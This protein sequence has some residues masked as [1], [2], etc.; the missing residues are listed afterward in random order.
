MNPP[1]Q[2]EQLLYESPQV[3]VYAAYAHSGEPVICLRLQEARASPAVNP[4]LQPRRLYAQL[5]SELLLPVLEM[6]SADSPSFALLKQDGGFSVRQFI[7]QRPPLEACFDFAEALIRALAAM[8]QAKIVLT[9]LTPALLWYHPDTATLRFLHLAYATRT[10]FSRAGVGFHEGSLPYIAPEQTGRIPVRPDYRSNYYSVGLILYELFTGAHPLSGSDTLEW[11]HQHLARQP[12]PAVRR[13]PEIGQ[14]LSDWLGKLLAKNPDD[15]YQSTQAMQEDLIAAR[16]LW[17]GGRLEESI[18]LGNRDF[19]EIFVLPE[20]IVGRDKDLAALQDAIADK[21][22][23]KVLLYLHGEEGIGKTAL[24]QEWAYRSQD[25]LRWVFGAHRAGSA[26]PFEALRQIVSGLRNECL[27]LPP[28]DRAYLQQQLAERTRNLSGVLIRFAPELAAILPSGNGMVS[29]DGT[30][31]FS[32]FAYA[33]SQFLGAFA[34]RRR[35][36]VL[37]LENLDL[38]EPSTFRL[39]DGLITDPELQHLVLIGTVRQR[40]LT[41]ETFQDFTERMRSFT[42]DRPRVRFREIELG[43]LNARHIAGLLETVVPEEQTAAAELIYHKT[44]G[45]PL[46]VRQLLHDMVDEGLFLRQE[47]ARAWRV[48]LDGLSQ[49][50]ATRNMLGLVAN[51][52]ESLPPQEQALLRLAA[53][54]GETFDPDLLARLSPE[55][56]RATFQRLSELETTSLVFRLPHPTRFGA[57][58]FSNER[59]VR[60]LR[61]GLPIEQRQ[62]LMA[63]ILRYYLG[64]LSEQD[65]EE[66]LFRL[67]SFVMQMP[68][69]ERRRW[70][71][72]LDRAGEKA[73]QQ[74][75]FDNAMAYYQSILDALPG[76]SWTEQRALSLDYFFKAIQ[77]A[78]FAQDYRLAGTWLDRLEPRVKGQDERADWFYLRCLSLVNQGRMRETVETAL[79]GLRELG[80]K[81]PFEPP[82]WRIIWGMIHMD[83]MYKGTTRE[84]IERLPDSRIPRR[85][86]YNRL[87]IVASPAIYFAA[88]KLLGLICEFRMKDMYRQGKTPY[89]PSIL[90]NYGFLTASFTAKVALGYD[91][92]RIGMDLN[93]VYGMPELEPSNRFLFSTF[94]EHARVNLRDVGQHLVENYRA[95]RELGNNNIGFYSLGVGIHYLWYSGESFDRLDQLCARYLPICQDA[96]QPM[97]E[98]YLLQVQQSLSELQRERFSD[99]LFMGP[100]LEVDPADMTRAIDTSKN[101]DTT[102]RG[103]YIALSYLK[104]DY[105]AIHPVGELILQYNA[106]RGHNSVHANFNVFF[107]LSAL[108]KDERHTAQRTRRFYRKH[109]YKLKHWGQSAP[110]HYGVLFRILQ[111]L[112]Y[113]RRGKKEA[114]ATLAEAYAVALEGDNP[115][116]KGLAAEEWGVLLY[117]RETTRRLGQKVMGEAWQHY[118]TWG[119]R[120]KQNQ[121]LEQW[122]DLV[123]TSGRPTDLM[124]SIDLDSV[125][126][127][128]QTISSEIRQQ[129]LLDRLLGVVMENAGAERGVFLVPEKERL[130][131]LAE[132]KAGAE[133][134]FSYNIPNADEMPE[135]MLHFV[136]E[137]HQEVVLGDAQHNRRYQD[138]PYMRSRQ[139]RSVICFPLVRNEELKAL[140]YLENNLSPNVFS[141]ERVELLRMLSSQMAISL[142]NAQLYDQLEEKVEERTRELNREKDKVDEL[143]RNILPDQVATELKEKGRAAAVRFEQVSVL[144]TDFCDFTL[145]ASRLEAEELVNLLDQYFS[146]FDRIIDEHRL[147]KIKTI[148]DAYMCAGG[149]PRPSPDDHHRTLRAALAIRN[150]VAKLKKTRSAHHEPYFDVRIGIHTGPVVAGIVGHRKFAYDIWG[151]TVNLASRLETHSA[152]GRINISGT[153]YELAREAFH[154]L[155]HDKLAGK[156]GRQTSMYW[157]EEER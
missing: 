8:H 48:D 78:I 83:R 59:L 63:P 3:A 13:R 139:V 57:Y 89:T 27:M 70:F 7:S 55:D 15:R 39:L 65:Q 138:D 121:L 128:S 127:A 98:A 42:A 5:T 130:I 96:G 122:P 1:I 22:P 29:L 154:C 80:V 46:F 155:P 135:R 47:D 10:T 129:P 20:Q 69:V 150:Y 24:L 149:I 105:A 97:I 113:H 93:P 120:A 67:A 58:R 81:L 61:E 142:E 147:E 14:A 19:P 145:T 140:I 90:V 36:L 110:Q 75:A 95:C 109:A 60:R 85:E 77:S 84:D 88:P 100:F 103:L 73:N 51:R 74:A 4:L 25:R 44:G 66:E 35:P 18:S 111:G 68:P 144:F 108:V 33:M 115:F 125:L 141:P 117:A 148:G 152:P 38:A 133:A 28:A 123:Q 92:S 104:G 2:D 71:D 106:E 50:P 107:I 32:R 87:V 34:S 54:I 102:L 132:K 11:L 79:T 94:M 153:L 137:Q 151:E 9:E 124:R 76:E 26:L 31:S 72:L 134:R 53:T 116:L 101:S 131:V 99:A 12:E 114:D 118:G 146:A 112:W 136:A 17:A 30:A 49:R 157:V 82:L 52:L 91:A 64:R 62:A 37:V 143:L 41:A 156:D 43:P 21:A 40:A 23:G 6:E 86:Y 16:H 119:A 126:K 56:P 45:N